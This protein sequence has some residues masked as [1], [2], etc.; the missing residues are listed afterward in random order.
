MIAAYGDALRQFARLTSALTDLARAVLQD[1][2]TVVDVSEFG[3]P[4]RYR[5]VVDPAWEAA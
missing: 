4:T 2:V 5:V 1:R 3:G